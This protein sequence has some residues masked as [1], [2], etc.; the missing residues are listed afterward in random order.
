MCVLACVPLRVA[1]MHRS[2]KK[3]LPTASVATETA[4]AVIPF[5]RNH[6]DSPLSDIM[7]LLTSLSKYVTQTRRGCRGWFW[8]SRTYLT[9]KQLTELSGRQILVQC[10]EG[11]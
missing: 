7:C 5:L 2:S 4:D 11:G 6:G 10:E 3:C 1:L 8:E 9:G